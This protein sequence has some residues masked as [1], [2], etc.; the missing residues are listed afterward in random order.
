[1][2]EEDAVPSMVGEHVVHTQWKEEVISMQSLRHTQ[3]C[4]QTRKFSGWV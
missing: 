1:M 3:L 4:R 2:E